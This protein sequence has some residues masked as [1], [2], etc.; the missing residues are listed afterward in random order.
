MRSIMIV[1]W[2]AL[3][4]VAVAVA[5]GPQKSISED[6]PAKPDTATAVAAP[7]PAHQ[8]DEKSIRLSAEAFAKA[9]NAGDAQTIARLFVVGGEVVNEEGQ[10]T[11]GRESIEQEFA[12]IFK[13]HPKTHMDLAIKSIRFI[14][15]DMAIEDGMAT[16]TH[17]PDEPAL[18]SPYSVT[19]TKQD[20]KWLT[21]S[22]RPSR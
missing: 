9:Y 10:P 3:A 12:G 19:Y 15:S 8:Q 7:S 14:G 5:R 6:S 2:V 21:T 17:A 20:G 1:V 13:E 4:M 18:H 11:K 22:A 16:V